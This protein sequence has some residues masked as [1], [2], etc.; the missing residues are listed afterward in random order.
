MKMMVITKSKD[1]DRL[2]ME[3][4]HIRVLNRMIDLS[5]IEPEDY[6][7]VFE[8]MSDEPNFIAKIKSIAYFSN[9]EVF[10]VYKDKIEVTFLLKD[11]RVVPAEVNYEII[12]KDLVDHVIYDVDVVLKKSKFDDNIVDEILSMRDSNYL[13]NHIRDIKL[14]AIQYMQEREN[15]R[16]LFDKYKQQEIEIASLNAQIRYHY[17]FH[18]AKVRT[19]RQ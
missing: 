19:S 14:L 2:S 16:I 9:K 1:V 3:K 7:L 15:Y 8:D 17:A 12:N 13:L 5:E 10:F 18:A 4:A 11:S 6:I